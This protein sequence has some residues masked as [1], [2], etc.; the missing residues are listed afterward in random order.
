MITSR[1]AGS[2]GDTGQEAETMKQHPFLTMNGEWDVDGTVELR[3]QPVPV[4]GIDKITNTGSEVVEEIDLFMDVEGTKV[5]FKAYHATSIP[6]SGR[7]RLAFTS[8]STQLGSG[9]G[10]SELLPDCMHSVNFC[11]KLN[12]TE[13]EIQMWLND[14]EIK[15][16]SYSTDETGKRTGSMTIYKHKRKT[17]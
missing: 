12:I 9:S 6:G 5:P 10:M 13:H 2:H 7:D 16:V 3:G 4:S 8:T 11:D 17:G 1:H 15:T 14:R